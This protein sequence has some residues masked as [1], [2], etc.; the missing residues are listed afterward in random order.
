[1]DSLNQIRATDPLYIIASTSYSLEETVVYEANEKGEITSL[2][3]YGFI[4][5]RTGHECWGHRNS[6]VIFVFPRRRYYPIK[7]VGIDSNLRQVLFMRF[8]SKDDNDNLWEMRYEAYFNKK[9]EQPKMKSFFSE[10]FK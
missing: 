8:D 5:K 7:D 3:A 2:D 6:A 9:L 4:A 1:M 10:L